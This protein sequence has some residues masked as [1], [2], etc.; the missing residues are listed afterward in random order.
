MIVGW[1]DLVGE[2]AKEFKVVISVHLSIEFVF[3]VQLDQLVLVTPVK[4]SLKLQWDVHLWNMSTEL[5]FKQLCNYTCAV[6]N[7]KLCLMPSS[8]LRKENRWLGLWVLWP[9]LL[10]KVTRLY[11]K[12]NCCLFFLLS[13][14]AFSAQTWPNVIRFITVTTFLWSGV[15]LRESLVHRISSVCPLSNLFSGF[16]CVLVLVAPCAYVGGFF[17]LFVSFFLNSVWM[18][19]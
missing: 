12:E 8:D 5:F 6:E 9:F 11:K 10:F 1:L 15:V 3:T 16:L 7:S 17:C 2:N 19:N 13:H 18:L 14:L 4:L